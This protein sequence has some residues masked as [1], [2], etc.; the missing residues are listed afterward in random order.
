M[1]KLRRLIFLLNDVF[2]LS[3]ALLAAIWLRFEQLEPQQ[4]G[5]YFWLL[6]ATVP[7]ALGI[8]W[9]FGLYNRSLR[10]TSIHDVV[11]IFLA[12]FFASSAKTAI[13]FAHQG[14]GHSRAILILD[15]LL[16]LFM[17]GASRTVPRIM[18]NVTEFE[19]IRSMV[20]GE[21]R[22]RA[23]RVLIYGAGRAGES[24]AREIRRNENFP[25][26]I[27]GF[28]DDFAQKSGQIIHGIPVLG[29]REVLNQVV[30]EHGVEEI[31]IA[32]PSASG[33]VVRE[34]VRLVRDTKIRFLTLPGLQ[35]LLEGKLLSMQLRSISVEDLLRRPPADIN[36]AEI[37][38]YITGKVVLI[39]GAGGSIGSEICR[40]IM[41]FKPLA[42]L[43]VGQ[44]ENSIYQIHQEL[45][46][47]AELGKTALLPIIADVKD[48]AKI[49]A[50][51]AAHQPHI[52]F[53][54][55]AHKHVPLMEMNPEEAVKN[56]ILGTM[57][58]VKSAHDS[59]VERFVMISTDKAV[60]PTSV[61][62][63][64]KRVAEMVLKAYAKRSATR[65]CAVRFGNVL[66]SRGS[67]IPLFKRQIERGGPITVT[68]P[69]MIRYFMT[70][71]EASR[72]VIQAGAF[73]K[74][75]EVFLLDMGEPVKIADLA[76]D[77]IRLAGL[78]EGKDIKIE[79]S[80]V[81]P[82]EK[83]YE[84]LLTAEEGITATRNKRIF[85]AKPEELDEEVVFQKINNLLE[86]V[87][88]RNNARIIDHL[89]ETVVSYAPNRD[90]VHN[91]SRSKGTERVESQGKGK[92]SHL[93]VV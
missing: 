79:F 5:Y 24:V 19:P 77:L 38:A 54:A 92:K 10:Y 47:N 56:N 82:G 4:V 71:P 86:S 25:Y 39:T 12:V 65:F 13:V 37:A 20:Y 32:I 78:E 18:L 55:A 53:H 66:G 8:F 7:I 73:G 22:N 89:R 67:V 14:V 76:S 21:A 58:L 27:V 64:T 62:G 48:I 11:A 90:H 52:V 59:K 57:N 34:I 50:V 31:I 6:P 33:D 81:R 16:S 80:G 68:H 9:F 30:K 84:E 88:C 91:P 28:I 49:E 70:I 15:W 87:Q 63:A 23:K 41:P 44:G 75:G 40:Q 85:I 26:Q 35:D 69:N 1:T 17:I 93:K 42:L 3:F 72:L 83:L 60:N 2:C 61:M 51:F 29:N 46:E 36:L 45:K 43:L 74:G